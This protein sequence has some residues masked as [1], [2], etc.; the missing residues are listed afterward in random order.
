VAAFNAHYNAPALLGE[1]RGRSP[2]TFVRL[3]TA[4]FCFMLSV[5]VA[6]GLAGYFVFG[7]D[8]EQNVMDSLAGGLCAAVAQFMMT[9]AIVGTYPLLF[10][11]VK[12]S[13]KN[14]ILYRNVVRLHSKI[15]K[16][17]RK[18]TCRCTEITLYLAITVSLWLLAVSLGDVAIMVA[19]MQSLLGTAIV[20]IFPALFC[21]KMI[22]HKKGALDQEGTTRRRR[23]H[24]A[25]GHSPSPSTYKVQNAKGITLRTTMHFAAVTVLCYFIIG[26]GVVTAIG[27]SVSS[28]LMW[29]RYIE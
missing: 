14:L 2:T 15:R 8:V 19:F 9:A 22:K 10:W 13:A 25:R 26:L 20:V 23:L 24:R 21:L 6:M 18:Y 7:V 4:S 29:S 27:G 16:K 12:V 17:K 28:I 1:L 3:S 11:N 5:N